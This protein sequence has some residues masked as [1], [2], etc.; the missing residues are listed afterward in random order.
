MSPRRLVE[1]ILRAQGLRDSDLDSEHDI[2]LDI[3]VEAIVYYN[4]FCTPARHCSDDTPEK[5]AK[6]VTSLAIFLERYSRSVPA[7]Q[8]GFEVTPPVARDSLDQPRLFAFLHDKPG[9]H[10]LTCVAA[11]NKPAPPKPSEEQQKIAKAL[12]GI[13]VRAKVAD[14]GVSS[15]D[16]KFDSLDSASISFTSDYIAKTQTVA[17]SGVVGYQFAKSPFGDY[18]SVIPYFSYTGKKLNGAGASRSQDIGNVGGGM[19]GD[20]NFPVNGYYQNIQLSSQYL[21]SYVTDTDLLTGTLLYTPDF[22][23]PG[24]G[25]AYNPNDGPVSFLLKP[26]AKF[27]YGS[28]LHAG[29]NPSLIA[30]NDYSRGGGRIEL[31]LFGEQGA[32]KNFTFNSSY[33]YLKVWV[34]PFDAVW[35]WE[36]TLNYVFP[37]QKNWSLQFKYSDGRNLDTLEREKLLTVG[38]GFKQ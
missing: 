18:S 12:S 2:G 21:H 19:L 9:S 28:V 32:L 37:D 6:A 24:V 5:L 26:Q 38:V 34:G 35:R 11:P 1:A 7:D 17:A 31:W 23:F 10:R 25:I 20:F 30:K 4:K 13:V 16:K 14:L 3:R 33:E 8:S 22:P 29:S 27:L 36:N 15:A